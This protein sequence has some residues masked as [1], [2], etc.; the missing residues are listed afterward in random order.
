MKITIFTSSF[1]NDYMMKRFVVTLA[2]C[3]LA[4]FSV[5][6]KK[7]KKLPKDIGA[8]NERILEEGYHLYMQEKVAWIVED[9]FFANQPE[10]SDN[11][12]GWVPV[13][14]DGQNVQG[15]FFNKEKTKVLFEVSIN[16][17]T[18]ETSSNA[19]VRELTEDELKEISL[20]ETVIGAVKTLDDLP[21]APEG[22]SFNVNILKLEDDLYRV[23]WM[24]G[25][26]QHNLIPFGCDFS[27]DCDSKGN[28]KE[29]RKYHNSYI[30]AM[31]IMDGSPVEGIWHSHTQ[32]SPFITPTDIALFL[33]Y[34][35][36]NSPLTGFRVYSTVYRCYFHFDANSYQIITITE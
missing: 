7:E 22:C 33:L 32:L 15:I 10:D 31:L 23:Y 13:T 27:Y 24:L 17:E 4:I 29:S 12:G 18:G 8:I 28:I 30:P 2:L 14:H 11:I 35:Y 1:L 19:T 34:G 16:L 21:A 20:R 5:D 3:A 26:A 9:V 6:A 36:G 25:T